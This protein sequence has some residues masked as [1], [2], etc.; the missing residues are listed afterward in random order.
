MKTN[1]CGIDRFLRIVIGIGLVSLVF[2]LEGSLKWLGLVGLVPLLTGVFGFCPLYAI[3]GISSCPLK[4][5]AA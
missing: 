3:L 2:V 4:S 1:V 5:R